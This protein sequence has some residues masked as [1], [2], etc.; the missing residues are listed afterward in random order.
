MAVFLILAVGTLTTYFFNGEKVSQKEN[1]LEQISHQSLN[2]KTP[3]HE[4]QD[5]V[6]LAQDS[7]S[8]KELPPGPK[9]EETKKIQK[10]EK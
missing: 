2:I 9:P 4:T 7:I 6:R 10:S 3:L 1:S 8:K 5:E